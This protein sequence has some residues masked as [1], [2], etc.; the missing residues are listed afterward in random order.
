MNNTVDNLPT[1]CAS[2]EY[3]MRERKKNFNKRKERIVTMNRESVIARARAIGW[4]AQECA[5]PNHIAIR[6]YKPD[7][8]ERMRLGSSGELYVRL[9]DGWMYQVG[10]VDDVDQALKTQGQ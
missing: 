2:G 1:S 8:N 10:T 7:T 3:S 6:S 5:D 4:D 9:D